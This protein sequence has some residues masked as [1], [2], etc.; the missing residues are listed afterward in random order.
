[1]SFTAIA[2]LTGSKKRRY[3]I[4]DAELPHL[5]KRLQSIAHRG[6]LLGLASLP[7]SLPE[8]R[9][10]AIDNVPEQASK[11]LPQTCPAGQSRPRGHGGL[12]QGRDGQ[13]TERV[14]PS[15]PQ[16]RDLGHQR[17][18][19][20]SRALIKAPKEPSAPFPEKNEGQHRFPLV[21][22]LPGA[23]DPPRGAYP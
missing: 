21:V 2:S 9:L 6:L 19:H 22:D 17:V 7:F 10:G 3:L 12:I 1:M 14:V 11:P 23:I 16:V 5:Q 8:D 4:D 15:R 20:S 13:I 18:Q